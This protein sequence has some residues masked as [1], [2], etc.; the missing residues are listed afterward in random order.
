MRIDDTAFTRAA[1]AFA[2]RQFLRA[3]RPA[4]REDICDWCERN[5]DLGFDHTSSATGLVHL[6]PYQREILRACDDPS[7]QEVTIQA[8]QRLGKSQLWKFSML[9]RVHDGGLSGLIVYPS[10]DL[11]ERTNRDTVVPLLQ[12]LPEA[13]KD[14]ASRGNRMKGSFH[15]PSLA[16]IVYFLGGGSQ[17]ISATANWVVLDE[18]DFIEL[19]NA[20]DDAKNMSQIKALRLRMQS[21]RQR[22]MIVCSSPSQF[23]GVVHQ[24][25]KR[26]SQGEWNMRCLH[27]GELSPTNKLSFFLDGNRWAG[28]QWSKDDR[29]EIV[30][31][32]IRWICPK[33]LHPHEYAEAHEMNERGAFVHARP[34]NTLHRS[35]Q[36]GALGNP[37]L[38]SWREIAQAQEDAVDGD[39]KK[40][41]A[42]T[43]LGMP[44][45]HVAE[46]DTS[47]GIKEANERRR[48]EYPADLGERLSVVLMGIDQQKSEL[49]GQKYYVCAVR[50]FCENG[51]SYL[52]SAGTD[53]TLDDVRRRLHGEWFGRRVALCLCDNGGFSNEED[54][55]ILVRTE[56]TVY[57]YKGT[58]G[59]LL[60]NRPYRASTEMPK[61]FLCDALKY[62]VKLLDLLYSP[63][64][65]GGYGW[66][67]PL[68]VDGEYFSQ[69]CNVRPNT[70]MGKDSNGWEYANWAA[71]SGDRRDF[72]DA[73]KMVL[74]ALDIAIDHLPPREFL[75][76]R[77]PLFAAREKL[78]ALVRAKRSRR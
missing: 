57:Y 22:M 39:G 71:F 74:A 12:T 19:Q 53:N 41:L 68:E 47:V 70:R 59:K 67:L 46:G 2:S 15:L 5:I 4:V 31:D 21:F 61:L 58:S 34:S 45:K 3:I 64:R 69:L 62:Q 9:K 66:F 1:S 8:G 73:E 7:V 49:A 43:I 77:V 72:F 38:W 42:N 60:E 36:C 55:D 51:D 48:V 76:G 37:A 27:C 52:L 10:L 20:E 13:A 63:R 26:G 78:L 29:G 35:F 6:Y 65:A 11:A 24:N 18:S 56:P 16:S 28:L 50:G 44:Y 14:L 33:C 25:W 32:S 40:Y 30:T 75:H 54:L 17:V 23:G